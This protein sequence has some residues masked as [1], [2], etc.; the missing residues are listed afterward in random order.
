[1][2]LHEYQAK[3]LLRDYGLPIPRGGVSISPE[4]AESR[5]KEIGGS[6]WYVKAQIHA[7]G[8]A[9]AG[10][11]KLVKSPEEAANAARE[12]L[13]QAIVTSQT[14]A[15][16]LVAKKAYVEEAQEVEREFYAAV[17]I[18][19]AKARV[20][21]IVSP[22]GGVDIEKALAEGS[23]ISEIALEADQESSSL[24]VL[25]D[26]LSLDES[27]AQG[28]LQILRSLYKAFR[29]QDAQFIEIN[30]LAITKAG[31]PAILDAKIVIDDNALFR[32]AKLAEFRDEDEKSPEELEANRFELNYTRLDGN[33]A[34]M[35]TGAGLGMAACDL[36]V[37]K[38]GTAG[39]FMDV[40]P[41]ASRD[42][43][44][45]GV[46]LLLSDP[47]VKAILV[48]AV[49]GGIL[50]CDTLAEGLAKALK[51][52]SANIPVI[53]YAA[54]TGKEIAVMTL[55]NQGIAAELADSLD[56]AATK[57]VLAAKGET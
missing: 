52:E 23:G 50:R 21:V 25:R 15:D 42:Q 9:K 1:M 48:A 46:Q 26:N 12:M 31:E 14:G 35:V 5:A 18:D 47:R 40:R 7:G 4:G 13:S 28:V 8:R 11:V 24:Q 36:I 2:I 45:K 41:V 32:Q 34:T 33:I 22:D 27:Q 44:A 39:N 6:A 17:L 10:A 51:S 56:Q 49:G 16:G 54:G 38:G 43:V 55:K 19:G 30:P 20:K 57:A 29:E 37:D 53:F 3:L